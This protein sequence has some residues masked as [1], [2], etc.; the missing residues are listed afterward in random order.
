MYTHI[1]FQ[2]TYIKYCSVICMSTSWLT[3]SLKESDDV[4]DLK[5]PAAWSD[6]GRRWWAETS[7]TRVTGCVCGVWPCLRTASSCRAFQAAFLRLRALCGIR[8]VFR[9]GALLIIAGTHTFRVNATPHSHTHVVHRPWLLTLRMKRLRTQWDTS[10]DA[11]QPHQANKQ[12]T[13]KQKKRDE[14]LILVNITR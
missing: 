10:S 2:S 4:L 9:G 6:G 12:P 3:C 13:D 5:S 11:C 14:V 1:S 8:K 7:L